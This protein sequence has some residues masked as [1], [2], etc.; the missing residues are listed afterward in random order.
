MKTSLLLRSGGG[1]GVP[2]HFSIRSLKG[3]RWN[4]TFTFSPRSASQGEKKGNNIQIDSEHL[5]RAR[6]DTDL[7]GSARVIALASFPGTVVGED[8]EERLEMEFGGGFG[9]GKQTRT[10]GRGGGGGGDQSQNE[11]VSE[12][13]KSMLSSD[14][15]NTLLL[16][17]Y[18]QFLHEVIGDFGEAEKYYSRAIVLSPRDGDLLSLYAKLLWDE[19]EKTKAGHYYDLAAK[20]SPDDRFVLG[21]QAYFLWSLDEDEDEVGVEN[22]A[23][24]LQG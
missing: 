15:N 9:S 1:G 23:E 10:R 13:Y 21:A 17:N 12:Y 24:F 16:R 18:G 5:R 8:E 6:S 7:A 14:P 2:I 20:A 4:R 11:I 19:G 22:T 3:I